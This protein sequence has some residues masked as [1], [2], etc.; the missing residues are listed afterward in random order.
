M[1]QKDLKDLFL[2]TDGKIVIAV[3]E[4][5]DPDAIGSAL[6][7]HLFL[8]KKG[9]ESV[10]V[11]KD[12]PPEPLDF[13]EGFQDIVVGHLEE[14][15]LYVLVD[16]AEWERTGLPHPEGPIVKIDH[17]ISSLRYSPYD[18]VDE[19]APAT[20]H[21]ILELLRD[22]D[23]GALDLPI[24]ESLYTGLLTDTGSFTYSAID[25][26]M[27]DALYLLS[28]GVDG[29]RVADMVFR[30]SPLERFKLIGL[31]LQT[32]TMEDRVAWI[33]VRKEFYEITGAKR[34]YNYGIV[35]YALSVRGA[36]VGIKFEEYDDQWHVSLRSKGNI[37]ISVIAR[38]FGGGG[39]R[40]AAAFRVP[41]TIG[42]EEL[43]RKVVDRIK[44]Y[45]R[46]GNG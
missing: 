23:E 28:R 13:L 40:N 11:S 19:T 45:L 22:W 42:E 15:A 16:A 31:A 12:E 20:A 6:G 41:A 21:L 32:L 36:L 29:R 10:V 9:L 24:A 25:V 2:D 43:V 34:S 30:N 1:K 39:H 27:R 4:K 46:H 3:H 26:A 8:R 17:H 38:E 5:P 35:D 18:M 7:L 44:E 33:V 37:D 14:G